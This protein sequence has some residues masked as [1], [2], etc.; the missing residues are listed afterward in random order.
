VDVFDMW[1]WLELLVPPSERDKELLTST[2]R[3]W[4]VVGKL[5]GYNSSNLQVSKRG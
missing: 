4:F 2:I 3:S 1:V 5:G